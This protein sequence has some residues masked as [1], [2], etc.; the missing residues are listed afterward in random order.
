AFS[1][2]PEEREEIS[3]GLA[4]GLPIR[5]IAYGLRRCPST[6]SREVARNDGRARY[7][8]AE[9]DCRAWERARRPKA[10]RLATCAK[11]RSIVSEKL[12]QDWSP[13]QISAWLK[14]QFPD[15]DEMHVSHETI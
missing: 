8:A 12:E 1:L 4:A 14:L 15:D 10:C 7:R 9:A 13:E 3:R 5:R 6:I 11:L 2:R